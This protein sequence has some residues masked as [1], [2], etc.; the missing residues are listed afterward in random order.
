LQRGY[1]NS[2]RMSTSPKLSQAN[3]KRFVTSKNARSVDPGVV[4]PGQCDNLNKPCRAIRDLT[5]RH[6]I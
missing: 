4:Y 2:G 6:R 3:D 5:L 1:D